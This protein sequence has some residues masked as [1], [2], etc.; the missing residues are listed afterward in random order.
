MIRR[1]VLFFFLFLIGFG[2]SAAPVEVGFYSGYTGPDGQV[3]AQIVKDFEA[4]NPS[5]KVNITTLQFTPL[6]SKFMTQVKAGDP[7]DILH[8]HPQEMAFFIDAGLFDPSMVER[9][10]LKKQEFAETPWNGVLYKGKLY[11]VPVDSGMYGLYYNKSLFAKEGI[12]APPKTGKDLV[13]VAL[14]L[15]VDKNGRR[16]N[17]PGFDPNNVERYGLGM[18]TNHFIFYMWY[19]LIKQQ[20]D[21]L[22]DAS[23][24]RAIFDEQKGINA[25]QFLYDLVYKHHVVPKGQKAAFDDFRSGKTAM[26]FDGNWQIAQLLLSPPNFEVDVTGYPQVFARKAAWGAGHVFAF[27]VKKASQDQKEGALKLADY[28]INSKKYVDT[29]HLPAKIEIAKLLDTMPYRKWLRE[30][31]PYVVILPNIVKSL[32]IYSATAPSPILTAPQNIMLNGEEPAKAIKLLRS[33]LNA[34]L[35]Q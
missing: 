7:P 30:Q 9:M 4:A 3:V 25:F 27:P 35:A 2:L 20:N 6:F 33:D 21:E 12:T 26:V 32:Q 22:F 19:S 15:T 31:G 14:K 16:A 13:D 8:L 24:Q 29:G 1:A 18:A 5:I 34:A 10:G 28:I 11:G 17:Q 23:E